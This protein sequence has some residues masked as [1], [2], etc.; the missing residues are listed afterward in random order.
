[1]TAP[2]FV[3]AF[4]E[5]EDAIP[6]FNEMRKYSNKE[7]LKGL[8]KELLYLKRIEAMKE[9]KCSVDLEEIDEDVWEA[10]KGLRSNQDYNQIFKNEV[11]Q[12]CLVRLYER[13]SAGRSKNLSN[14]RELIDST[15]Q[16]TTIAVK[17]RKRVVGKII[18]SL[19]NGNSSVI[20][21]M[22]EN[23]VTMEW[24][25]VNNVVLNGKR[26]ELSEEEKS[27]LRYYLG[28]VDD[29]QY[30]IDNLAYTSVKQE[31]VYGMPF[32]VFI[33]RNPKSIRYAVAEQ[34]E[35]IKDLNDRKVLLDRCEKIRKD[36]LKFKRLYGDY[37]LTDSDKE[38]VDSVE[39]SDGLRNILPVGFNFYD[40]PDDDRELLNKIY[41]RCNLLQPEYI[42]ETLG[43][44][45]DLNTVGQNLVKLYI[46]G[47]NDCQLALFQEAIANT[48]LSPN[49]FY[50][51]K[52][53]SDEVYSILDNDV[54]SMLDSIL[55][56]GEVL[57]E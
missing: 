53:V 21:W 24:D 45:G 49:K 4:P 5:R 13:E 41:D 46:C 29:I 33:Q 50:I 27:I 39:P 11:E 17:D 42:K 48:I 37:V 9:L 14:L 56:V 43:C 25:V 22:K 2:M 52:D 51:N 20:R 26:Y 36:T 40:L 34:F 19:E 8:Q 15:L 55:P 3:L 6:F 30:W 16:N 38:T 31:I 44:S 18:S 57:I 1:M 23:N 12:E 54:L 47:V 32:E 10:G 7:A 35:Q 28:R